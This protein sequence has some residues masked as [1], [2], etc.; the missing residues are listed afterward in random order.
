V[1]IITLTTDFGLADH[2]VGTMKGV[3]LSGCPEGQIVD[4][5]HDIPPFALY[6]GAYAIDQAA[7]YF[8]P[9]TIHVVVVDPGVGTSRKPLLVEALGQ[10]FIAPDNGVLSLIVARDSGAICREAANRRLWLPG[11]SSTFHG[12]DVFTPLA[13]ALASGTARPEDAGPTIAKIELLPDIDPM[14]TEPGVWCGKVLS[15]DRFGNLIT[16]FKVLRGSFSLT[17]GNSDIT[18][19]RQTFGEAA[20]GLIFAYPG[21]SGYLEVGMNRRSAAALLQVGPGDNITLRLRDTI[22]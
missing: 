18:E 10:L 1:P 6:A 9:G 3:L 17:I 16:N 4:I 19:F 21:S 11:P 22:S 14:E 5:T 7:P 15:I 13:A 8:P 12:R 2:Y 20:E